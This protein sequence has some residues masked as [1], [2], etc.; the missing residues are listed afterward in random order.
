M[1]KFTE[2]CFGYFMQMKTV[3]F[4]GRFIHHL[5]LYQVESEHKSVM[6]FEFNGVGARFDRKAFSMVTG[7]NCGKFS[8]A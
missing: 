5:L 6:E 1:K 2:S 8:S 4:C 3:V 7:L